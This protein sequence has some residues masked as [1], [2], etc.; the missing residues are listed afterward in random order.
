MVQ[1]YLLLDPWDRISLTGFIVG[2]AFVALTGDLTVERLVAMPLIAG[3]VW[4]FG[5]ALVKS[6]RAVQQRK[7]H[8]GAS[9]ASE[10][11]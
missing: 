11:S 4:A 7:D 5:G 3:I 6:L 9:A 10:S 2:V 1:L 8:P